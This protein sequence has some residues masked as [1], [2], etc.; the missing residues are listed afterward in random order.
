MRLMLRLALSGVGLTVGLSGA[1]A[2]AQVGNANQLIQGL[3]ANNDGIIETGEVPESA[4]PQFEKV[5]KLADTN[6]DGR[7]DRDELRTMGRKLREAGPAMA[8]AQPGPIGNPQ[9]RFKLMDR[10]GDGKVTRD[11]F[12]GPEALFDRLDANKDGAIT[13]DEQPKP[14]ALPDSGGAGEGRAFM[15]N[16][17]KVLDKDGDG[18]LTRS[19]FTGVPEN[20]DRMDRDQDGTL[21]SKE[22]AAAVDFFMS[23]QGPGGATP[24]AQAKGKAAA[25][26]AGEAGGFVPPRFKQM[27]K[28]GDGK[29]TQSEFT[30]PA[31]LFYR[32]DKDGDGSLTMDEM[33]AFAAAKGQAKKP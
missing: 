9:E 26:G 6:K 19:E 13:K 15:L 28:D 31:P 10:D 3:D 33:K 27:D 23:V 32:M 11:E 24:K 7:L 1:S 12:T 17:F 16:R 4:R 22:L 21:S 18:K 14:G 5:L 29:V 30:G 2:F 8:K 20:F 25:K